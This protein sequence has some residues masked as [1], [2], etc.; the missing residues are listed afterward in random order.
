LYQ[1][2]EVGS[3]DEMALD[4]TV[5]A[6]SIKNFFLPF[7]EELTTYSFQNNDWSQEIEYRV[8]PRV[9]VGVRSC[10]ING[11]RKLDR[12]FM[13]GSYPSPY[14]VTRRKNT[15]IIG[16]DHKP[17]DDCFCESLG[18][19][20]VIDGFNLFCS[21]IGDKYYL[22]VNSSKAF[23]FLKKV[24]TEAPTNEDDVKFIER[25]NF[26]LK[27]FKAKV[28]FSDLP[29]ILD[30]EFG[31]P[32]WKDLAKKCLN[33]GTCAMVCPTCYCH[34]VEETIATNLKTASKN[35]VQYSCNLVDFALVAGGHNFR[36][37]PED[38][39][40][41]RYY[42]H[43]RGFEENGEDMICVGCNRCGRACLADIKPEE[44]INNLRQE[45]T[46]EL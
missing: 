35:R 20:T 37:K 43:Y 18:Q 45:K 41:Y 23:N 42:H 19:H 9:I 3:F 25:K 31:S 17:L 2:K 24:K 36:P 28:D 22:S 38:K 1:F 34:G 8:H 4:Y 46:H 29:N 32:I 27:S 11:L 15:F 10:D 16:M 33:C 6:S 30:I 39:L 44:V 12:I 40:R 5:T 21:D 13:N 26:I 7:Q 14:Y